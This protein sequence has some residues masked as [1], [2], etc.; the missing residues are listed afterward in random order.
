MGAWTTTPARGAIRGLIAAWLAG[1]GLA[2]IAAPPDAQAEDASQTPP[3]AA[4][5]SLWTLPSWPG[6]SDGPTWR[7]GAY[8]G[9]YAHQKLQKIVFEPWL[10]KVQ[11]DYIADVHAVYTAYRFK[12]LPLDLEI[13]GGVAQRFGQDHQTEVDLIPM[14]RW[15]WFP[16]NRFVYTN[17]RVGLLGAS[18]ATGVSPRELASSGNDK[19]SR[20]LNFLVPEL[21]FSGGPDSPV[22]VFIRVHHRSGIFGLINGDIGGSNYPSIGLRFAVR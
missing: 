8:V 18:Y 11:P 14:A 20:F 3:D 13:E 17:L 19:G 15:K 10:V 5:P 9:A 1:V 2:M 4:T 22:E 21:T 12:R 16:W 7:V 6:Q